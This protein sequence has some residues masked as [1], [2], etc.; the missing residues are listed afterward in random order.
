MHISVAAKPIVW[1]NVSMAQY[2]GSSGEVC[3]IGDFK[4]EHEPTADGRERVAFFFDDEKMCEIAIHTG[5]NML[6]RV[7]DFVERFVIIYLYGVRDGVSLRCKNDFV[8]INFYPTEMDTFDETCHLSPALSM[9]IAFIGKRGKSR[10]QHIMGDRKAIL[11]EFYKFL[12]EVDPTLRSSYLDEVFT[13]D[14]KGHYGAISGGI[15]SDHEREVYFAALQE[16]EDSERK[17]VLSGNITK[18]DK[19][20]TNTALVTLSNYMLDEVVFWDFNFR[21]HR[22]RYTDKRYPNISIAVEFCTI[23]KAAVHNA[24]KTLTASYTPLDEGYYNFEGIAHDVET[25]GLYD[26]GLLIDAPYKKGYDTFPVHAHITAPAETHI[27]DGDTVRG[28]VRI[29]CQG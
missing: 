26:Y 24:V 22:K 4:I 1:Y 9:D 27:S 23:E 6:R 25:D 17:N 20:D 5:G 10:K 15:F 8:T 11:H 21:K 16:D 14:F 29:I 12:V 2:G 19:K 13:L 7:F 3:M 18:M 28:R